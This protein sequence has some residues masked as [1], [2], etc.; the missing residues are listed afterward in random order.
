[1]RSSQIIESSETIESIEQAF[2]REAL[3]RVCEM[4]EEDFVAA[5]GMQRVSTPRRFKDD[6][7]NEFYAYLD[8]GSDVLAVAHLD[9]V[10]LAHERACHFLDTEGGTVVYSRALDDRLG[11]YIILELLPK[12]GIKHDILLT[13]GEEQGRSTAQHFWPDKDY[14]SMIEFDR[15]GTDVVMYQY[16]DDEIADLVRQSGARVGDGIFSDISYMEH[17]G[18]KG[19]NWGVGYQDYHYPRAHA[20]LDDTFSM[21]AK[22]LRFHEITAGLLLEHVEE[23]PWETEDETVN[24]AL[25]IWNARMSSGDYSDLDT[26]DL[27]EECDHEWRIVNHDEANLDEAPDL[28]EALPA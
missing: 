13:V 12:L 5:Y 26:P 22:Y 17:L 8:N 14:N 19:F 18:I 10:G 7:D 9:T 27:D 11:A 2:D 24:L 4:P 25:A 20:Y 21:V 6:P 3:R 23:R 28:D 15:G 1:M 16:E